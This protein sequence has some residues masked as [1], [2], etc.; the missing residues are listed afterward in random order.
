[1]ELSIFLAKSI[2]IILMLTALALFN[3]KNIQLLFNIYK[4]PEAVFLTGIVDLSLGVMLVLA[5][6][7][8]VS[9]FRV[10]ITIIGWILVLRGVGRIFFPTRVTSY[11]EKFKKMQGAFP[12]FLLVTFLI[13]AYLAYMGFMS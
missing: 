7:I 13:A 5:H 1:M 2:G 9:D 6:N 10:A 3:K 8:W 11:L 12:V 4:N